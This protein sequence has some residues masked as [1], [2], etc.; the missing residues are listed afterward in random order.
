MEL[1]P[2]CPKRSPKLR[3]KDLLSALVLTLFSACTGEVSGAVEGEVSDATITQVTVEASGPVTLRGSCPKKGGCT[4]DSVGATRAT[5]VTC[6][7]AVGTKPKDFPP[8][9]YFKCT[10][11]CGSARLLQGK[12]G[13][14]SGPGTITL[15]C[16][17]QAPL[18][19]EL[20]VESP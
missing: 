9:C 19:C 4:G 16:N 15:T 6:T 14:T 20:R 3:G 17:G 7:L 13:A 1:R 18:R 12:S 5:K 8:A 10:P 2:Y 11:R